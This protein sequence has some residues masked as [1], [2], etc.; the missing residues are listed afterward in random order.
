M[1]WCCGD[2]EIQGANGDPIAIDIS[3]GVAVTMTEI[4][5]L[6]AEVEGS[7]LVRNRG[8]LTLIDS[9]GIGSN[10]QVMLGNGTNSVGTMT[11]I[12]TTLSAAESAGGTAIRN[13]KF[14]NIYQS[15]IVGFDIGI[16]NIEASISGITN[17]G[18]ITLAKHHLGEHQRLHGAMATI[19]TAATVSSAPAAA[20]Q[21][22]P[23]RRRPLTWPCSLRTWSGR[24]PTTA[25]AARPTRYRPA[26]RP[27]T[28]FPTASAAAA[29]PSPPTSAASPV[30][31]TDACDIGAFEAD[32]VIAEDADLVI[33]KAVTP[34]IAEPG[35]PVT[36]TLTFSNAGS[37][38]ATGAS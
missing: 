29:P 9:T 25:A 10:G 6:D 28:L 5:L 34:A 14:V 11:L 30:R 7:P 3:P 1:S 36:Y 13:R 37:A 38:T 17:T 32:V 4:T 19:T 22:T 16:N 27:W 23:A 35:Q 2:L 8:D 33:G 31:R 21:P 18:V 12:N 26:A 15:T 20:V 24:W